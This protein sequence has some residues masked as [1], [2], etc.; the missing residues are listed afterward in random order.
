[1]CLPLVEWRRPATKHSRVFVK[2]LTKAAVLPEAEQ[3]TEGRI[4]FPFAP[5]EEAS[6]AWR[7]DKREEVQRAMIIARCPPTVSYA[8]RRRIRTTIGRIVGGAE[9]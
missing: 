3:P 1:M 8:R 2:L 6:V 4:Y 9:L 5:M 7:L